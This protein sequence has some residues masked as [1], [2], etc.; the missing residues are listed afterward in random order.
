MGSFSF[1]SYIQGF[2]TFI[3]YR[4]RWFIYFFSFMSD[5]ITFSSEAILGWMQYGGLVVDGSR[6]LTLGDWAAIYFLLWLSLKINGHSILA[7]LVARWFVPVLKIRRKKLQ[8]GHA[9]DGNDI[10]SYVKVILAV[11]CM[12]VPWKFGVTNLKENDLVRSQDIY[13]FSFKIY[14]IKIVLGEMFNFF[15]HMPE[16]QLINNPR[17]SKKQCQA[18]N[19]A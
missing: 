11:I 5:F 3:H 13:F 16:A 10:S 9:G 18:A 1:T 8:N 15:I 2:H 7:I 19:R 17:A 12:R 14:L 6:S 4:K